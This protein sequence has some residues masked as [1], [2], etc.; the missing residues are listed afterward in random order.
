MNFLKEN[1]RVFI[2]FG[3]PIIVIFLIVFFSKYNVFKKIFFTEN[4]N[5]HISL[6]NPRKEF[7]RNEKPEFTLAFPSKEGE[8]GKKVKN[9]WIEKDEKILVSL[10]NRYTGRELPAYIQKQSNGKFKVIV[11]NPKETKYGLYTI[12][13]D[14]KTDFKFERNLSQDFAWGVLAVNTNKSMYLPNE[15]AKL[16]YGVL[17][18]RGNTLCNADLTVEISNPDKK[19]Q[20]FSTSGKSIVISPKCIGNTYSLENDYF[21]FYK[22]GKSGRYYVN[23][24]ARTKNGA[25]AISDYFEV[26][27]SIPYEVERTQFPSRIY[28]VESYPVKL[29]V[30]ANEDYKGNVYD[31]VPI[32]FQITNISNNGRVSRTKN[33][34]LSQKELIAAL[35]D[36][37]THLGE[38]NY[39]TK[40][41][42]EDIPTAVDKTPIKVQWDVD[43]KKGNTYT[44]TYNIYFPQ[45]SPEYYLLGP[46][47]VG[48]FKEVRDWQVASDATNCWTGSGV[49]TNWNTSANWGSG[50]PIST[51]NATFHGASCTTG[52]PDK[53]V[54]VNVDPTL[55][56]TGG[57]ITLSSNYAGTM[58]QSTGIT[59]TIYGT[60]GFVMAGGT[61]T[62]SDSLIDTSIF[63]HTG[64]TFT[65]TTGTLSFQGNFTNSGG[66][67]THNSGTVYLSDGSSNT[68]TFTGSTTLYNFSLFG[69][70]NNGVTLAIASGTTITVNNTLSLRGDDFCGTLLGIN[71]PGG[72]SAKGDIN[73][74]NDGANGTAVITLNGTGN[75]N[76]NGDGSAPVFNGCSSSH[77]NQLPDITINKTSGTVTIQNYIVPG[78]WTYTS[79]TVVTTGSTVIFP[80]GGGG[81]TTITGSMT[82]DNVKFYSQCNVGGTIVIASGTNVLAKGTLTLMNDT[83]CGGNVNGPGT[84]EVQGDLTSTGDALGGDVPITFS[85]PTDQTI[86][87]VNTTFPSGNVVVNKSAGLLTAASNLPFN[88]TGQ[89]LTITSGVLNLAGKNLAVDGL[90]TINGQLIQT[91]GS[92]TASSGISVGSRGVWQNNSTG[93]ISLGGSVNNA[94]TIHLDGNGPTCGDSDGITVRSSSNGVSRSW[95][96][97]GSTYLTDLD[98]KDQGSGSFGSSFETASGTTLTAGPF[99]ADNGDLVIAVV[100]AGDAATTFSMADNVGTNTWS[101]AVARQADNP[102]GYSLQTFY[103]KNVNGSSAMTVTATFS[104]STGWK[105]LIVVVVKNID[106][107]A[108]LDQSAHSEADAGTAISV[109][110]VTTTANGEFIFAAAQDDSGTNTISSN[111]PFTAITATGDPSN[112][113][114]LQAQY[115]VQPSSGSITPSWTMTGTNNA[116]TQMA[117][118]KNNG[119]TPMI[120]GIVTAYNST[121][122]GNNTWTFNPS[123]PAYSNR[124]D[125]K[126]TGG[127]KITGGTKL[128]SY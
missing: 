42:K 33:S 66:T 101:T 8:V 16:G 67:F 127:T 9:N 83:G 12:K 70:A 48:S 47:T 57:G 55:T 84:L 27:N 92:L 25:F 21:S 26:K 10:F 116:M 73:L 20:K 7:G 105:D 108:P 103:A 44:L 56:G 45:V 121:N 78:N 54:T 104:P 49:D 87:L 3:I 23:V 91:T 89:T 60:I 99:N 52:T 124:T 80:A 53:S 81:T 117:T 85:G 97:A 31:L 39:K 17:D 71:G 86:T 76:I 119:S 37:A 22:T 30:K 64:G 77:T 90:L 61:F 96:G 106:T 88:N 51:S 65:S 5:K 120:S 94:G 34:R 63:N 11:A 24:T 41:K 19:I 107:T 72:I 15:K 18:E 128:K 14:A 118:F 111:S 95:S 126:V 4:Q 13:V 74:T 59:M 98:A 40:Y 35:K 75:Q 114:Y 112:N 79:G 29:T 38:K 2:V 110:P 113:Y 32:D 125:T 58:T 43:W 50:T 1:Y 93:S 122:T 102:N 6:I 82:F 109:G 123:C 68:Y 46:F 69:S 36:E 28:P 100:G 115:Y 62:G